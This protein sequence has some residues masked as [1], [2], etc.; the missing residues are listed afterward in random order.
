MTA[1]DSTYAKPFLTVP[2][3]IR[4]LRDRGM[5]CGTDAYATAQLERYGYYRLSGY[6]HPYRMRPDN[7]AAQVDGE[8]REIR[9]DSFI[10]GTSLLHVVDL[11]EFDQ[12]LRARLSDALSTL[13]VSLRFFIGHSLG[14]IDK[15]SHRDPHALGAIRETELGG[16][17]EPTVS[18]REWLEEYDRHEKRAKD[19]F[20]LHFREKY[21]AHLPIWVATEV[22]SFGVLSNLYTLMPQADQEILAARFQVNTAVGRGDR[23]AFANWLNNLR[24]VRNICAHFGRTWNRS[25]DVLIDAPGQSRRESSGLLIRLVDSSISNKLYGVLVIMRYL[26]LS[27]DPGREDICDIANFIEAESRKVGFG[28]HQLGFPPD[29]RKDPIWSRGMRL[30]PRPMMAASMLDRAHSLTAVGARAALFN[31]EVEPSD[32]PRTLEQEGRAIKAA[33]RKLL[34]TYL[35]Y[36]VLIEIDLGGAKYYPDFQFRDGLIINALAEINKE[37]SSR[38]VDVSA[39]QIAAALLDWWQTPNPDLPVGADGMTRSP[40]ELLQAVPE[41]EFNTVMTQNE[42]LNRFVIPGIPDA[43]QAES[44]T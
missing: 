25:F 42:A 32:S 4:R 28:L 24:N 40:I 2:E 3:Q 18:Y 30:D 15:F 9:L 5:D 27:V 7:P 14:K 31:A 38:C 12:Q 26:M 41:V 43:A 29:W 16:S 19:S 37:L 33:Q 20:V 13:E 22:M 17:T 21:G 39:V 8:G 44:T 10:A 36:D 35:H 1:P 23:G 6:W 11:Y 34:R